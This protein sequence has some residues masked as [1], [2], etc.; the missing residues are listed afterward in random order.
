[1][2]TISRCH[3]CTH[4]LGGL[5]CRAFEGQIPDE[6]LRGDNDHS[7]PLNR[8]GN[9]FVFSDEPVEL[10]PELYGIVE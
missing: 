2:T 6:I 3:K 4:Y 5:T 9:S 10:T 8:Q 1:M 7:K